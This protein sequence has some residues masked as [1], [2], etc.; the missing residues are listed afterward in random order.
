MFA[1]VG[2]ALIIVVTVC[3]GQIGAQSAPPPAPALWVNYDF[4]PG[5]RVI[6][7]DD[8][9][10]DQVGNFP[11]RLTFRMGNMDVVEL[12]GER[13]LRVTG[14]SKLGI[15]L[16]EILP[17]KFTIEIDVINRK[18]LDGAAFRLQ[19]GLVWSNTIKT[20]SVDWGSDGVGLSGGGGGV[21]P[22]LNNDANKARYRG[23]LSQLRILGDGPYIKVYL[24]EK[25]YANIPNA[26]FERSRGLTLAAEGRGEENPVYIGRIRVAASDKTIYDELAA[27]GRVATQGILFDSGS[28]RIKP[29]STPTL[30]ELGAMLAAHPELK[31]MVEGHT[32]N[33]GNA[34][35]NLK[36]SEA[37]ATAV[38]DA[39]EKDYG[40][41]AGRL[42]GKGLGDTKPGGP[43]TTSEGRMN[44][45]RVELVKLKG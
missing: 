24:D 35:E 3:P 14:S 21:V 41:Q 40:V 12:G 23:K 13:F 1:K 25:R 19:G 20:S 15:P 29:E 5:N 18:V 28:D 10:A 7:F 11:K 42:Q 45:R 31:L 4:V 9:L 36:L 38:K 32:D 22:L 17:L 6:F 26:N 33:I 16:P 44:N 8:Y 27:K 39:L 2:L 43:N 37:R 34:A 30:K